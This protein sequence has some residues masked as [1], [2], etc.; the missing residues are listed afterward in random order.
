[1]L[2]GRQTAVDRVDAEHGDAVVA[3]VRHVQVAAVRIQR[4][5]GGAAVAGIGVGQRGQHL[6]RLQRA[7]GQR[8]GGHRGVQVIDD[9]EPAAG[10]GE[11]GRAA[12]RVRV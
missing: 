8:V 10:G 1:M 7:S 2:H 12:G 3:P 9:V 4:D 11:S 6:E 5:A